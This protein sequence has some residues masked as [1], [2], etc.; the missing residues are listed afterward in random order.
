[1][2]SVIYLDTHVAAWLFAGDQARLS[3]PARIAIE[4]HDLL[5]SPAALLELEYLYETKRTR[6]PGAAVVEDLGSESVCASA[7]CRSQTWLGRPSAS[8]GHATRSIGSS[9]DRRPVRATP[10]C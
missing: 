5:I 6:T 4:A 1:M 3:R 2:A 8:A 7:I 10:A 9:W